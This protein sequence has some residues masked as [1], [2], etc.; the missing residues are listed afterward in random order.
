MATIEV[1]EYDV[2]GGPGI[3]STPEHLGFAFALACSAM[4][5]PLPE[6]Q[7]FDLIRLEIDL[8]SQ[9]VDCAEVGPLRLRP[10]FAHASLHLKR[11]GSEAIGI[12]ATAALAH[13][14]HGWV[15]SAG[16]PKDLDLPPL[17]V[18]PRLDLVFPLVGGDVG[19]EARGRSKGR[20]ALTRT[21]EQTQRLAHVEDWGQFHNS[22]SFMAW[23]W[24]TPQGTRVDHFDPGEPRRVLDV[25]VRVEDMRRQ[26]TRLFASAREADVDMVQTG[27]G[28]ARGEWITPRNTG[29]EVFVGA[30]EPDVAAESARRAAVEPGREPLVRALLGP[31]AQVGPL[32]VA[33]RPVRSGIALA[34]LVGQVSSDD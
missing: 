16:W 8:V 3:P 13:L 27:R 20:Q 34:D 18:G 11:L 23:A 33:T 17:N 29:M 22:K 10:A 6:N 1:F 12:A 14:R 19:A 2:A 15:A 24:A 4:G 31:V 9:L 26:A 25:D 28:A 21:T 7:L 32:L 5:L 30:M